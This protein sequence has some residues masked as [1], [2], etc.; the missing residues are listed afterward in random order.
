MILKPVKYAFFVTGNFGKEVLGYLI[1]NNLIPELIITSDKSRFLDFKTKK[2]L[3]EVNSFKDSVQLESLLTLLKKKKIELLLLSDFG[4][5]IPKVLLTFPK[6]GFLNIHPSL[7]PKYRG[8]TPIQS[9]ILNGDSCSGVSIMLMNEKL[10]EGNI[11]AQSEEVKITNETFRE[12]ATKLA[13]VSAKLFLNILPLWLNKEIKEKPQ[14]KEGTSYCKTFSREDGK[15]LWQNYTSDYLEKMTRAFYPYPTV[16]TFFVKDGVEIR[17]Q[18]TNLKKVN[19]FN[20][21]TLTPGEIYIDKDKRIFVGCK[22][23]S[24]IIVLQVKPQNKKLMTAKDFVNGY[25]SYLTKFI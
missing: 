19:F 12:L 25:K 14:S 3:V 16:Y 15:I 7:L 22:D 1:Q 20:K 23:K 5:I 2:D 9:A 17:L 11:I 24:V 21:K 18:I 4:L 13:V 8:A 6:Y 10:D